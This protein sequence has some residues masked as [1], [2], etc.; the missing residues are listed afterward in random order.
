MS[1]LKIL[2]TGARA[3]V[4]LELARRFARA[5]HVV[6]LTDSVRFPLAGFSNCVRRTF[7]LPPPRQETTEY[8]KALRE[9]SKSYD[10]VV[11][12]CEDVL[13]VSRAIEAFCPSFEL[14]K[15][16]HN[17]YEFSRIAQ[18]LGL[19]V[20][21]T[22]LLESRGQALEILHSAKPTVFKPVYSRFATH[23]RVLP[24]HLDGVYPE[25]ERWVAQE[26]WPGD[27]FCS[28]SIAHGGRL[29][30]HI[31]YKPLARL[32]QG[33]GVILE[34]VSHPTVDRWVERFLRELS[35]TGQFAFD[36]IQNARGEVAA[37]ECNP[38]T[39][40]G[41][42]L[43]GPSQDLAG[44]YLGPTEG[45]LIGEPNR[46]AMLTFPALLSSPY[47]VWK[48]RPSPILL[49]RRDPLPFLAQ[50][51]SFLEFLWRARRGGLLEATTSDICWDGCES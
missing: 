13:W 41:V 17:K 37:I 36:F 9:L 16:L 35:L 44:A 6:D 29:A 47:Q 5:G 43:F 1:H 48:E 19:L 4:A 10:L 49:D 50:G 34:S 24:R 14:L 15:K 8:S 20:P 30:A 33:A 46:R 11:P 3:P 45:C 23:T 26:Y 12:T 38:R 27:H 25:R 22:I 2:I 32:G 28:F 42:H 31:V 51:I 7:R 40:S 39:T 21:E 18:R